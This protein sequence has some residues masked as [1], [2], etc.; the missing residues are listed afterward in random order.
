MEETSF[1]ESPEKSFL[2][3]GN[4]RC[5]GLEPQSGPLCITSKWLGWLELARWSVQDKI[6]EVGGPRT[7]RIWGCV[8]GAVGSH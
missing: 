4:S 6:Q 8:P 2:V 3:E 1:G 5:K 7:I